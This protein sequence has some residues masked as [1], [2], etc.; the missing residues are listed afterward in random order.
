[1]LHTGVGV[2]VLLPSLTME[3]KEARRVRT[4]SVTWH[5]EEARPVRPGDFPVGAEAQV[6]LSRTCLK[7]VS[8]RR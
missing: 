5:R 6:T 3:G 8:T 4:A 2:G 1:M 7:S